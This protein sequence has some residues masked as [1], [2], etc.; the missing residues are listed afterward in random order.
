M[1]SEKPRIIDQIFSVLLFSSIN[2]LCFIIKRQ[3]I[4]YKFLS[5]ILHVTQKLMRSRYVI[6]QLS[7]H[8]NNLF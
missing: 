8:K 6:F 5:K 2:W 3:N 1:I 7:G 4:E